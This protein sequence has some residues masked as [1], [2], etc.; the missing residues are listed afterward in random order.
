MSNEDKKQ[1][2]KDKA[3][4]LGAEAYFDEDNLP[5]E[6]KNAKKVF[7]FTVHNVVDKEG[8]QALGFQVDWPEGEPSTWNPDSTKLNSAQLVSLI[9]SRYL[10]DAVMRLLAK[11]KEHREDANTT[12]GKSYDDFMAELNSIDN[13]PTK[14]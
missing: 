3:E 8:N 13:P 5:E 4:S 12:N 11:N 9:L 10:Q 1:L 2:L 14:H 6:L 7:Q